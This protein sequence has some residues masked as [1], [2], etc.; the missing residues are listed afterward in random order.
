VSFCSRWVEHLNYV[1]IYSSLLLFFLDHRQ[2]S[3]VNHL[4]SLFISALWY[5]SILNLDYGFFHF[6]SFPA[7]L[8]PTDLSICHFLLSFYS[9]SLSFLA[10]FWPVV[11]LVDHFPHWACRFL[12]TVGLFF[13]WAHSLPQDWFSRVQIPADQS[14]IACSERHWEQQHLGRIPVR[15]N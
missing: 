9:R 15:W 4:P 3:S 11:I 1:V 7:T 6:T 13:I 2:F 8:C 12:S 10:Q 5:T 14:F